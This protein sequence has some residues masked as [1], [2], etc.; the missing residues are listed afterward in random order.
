MFS[1]YFPTATPASTIPMMWGMRSL[2]IMIGANSIKHITT[3]NISV[4]LVI[5][6]Y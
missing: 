5:G 1:P 3:K 2:L 6:K 4:G